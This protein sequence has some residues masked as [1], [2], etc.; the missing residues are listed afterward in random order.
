MIVMDVRLVAI[1][2][3]GTLLDSRGRIPEENIAAVQD[4]LEAGLQVVLVTGRSFPFARAATAS[5]PAVVSLIVSNGAI[6]RTMAGRTVARR[7][8]ARETA[9]DILAQTRAFRQH[10]AVLFDREAEGHVVAE[11]MDWDHPHRRGYWERH[12]HFIGHATPLEAALTEDPI[13]VMFNGDVAT[14]RAIHSVLEGLE[15]VSVCRTEY[16]RR[17]FSLVDVTAP[18]ATKG[19]ALAW[20]AAALGIEPRHVMAIGDNLNDLEM[21]EFAGVPVIMGN[22]VD[23]LHGRGWHETAPHDEAGVAQAIRRLALNSADGR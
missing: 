21:L 13:Q 19:Q 2:I 5:L 11:S 17:D 4:A 7:L 14:M 8:L 3:D 20:R 15:G 9:R 16:E 6:E 22:A 10:S 1:D 12:R 23:A 18:T